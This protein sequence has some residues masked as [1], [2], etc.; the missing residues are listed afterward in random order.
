M[1]LQQYSP[2]IVHPPTRSP[3]NLGGEVIHLPPLRSIVTNNSQGQQRTASHLLPPKH[4]YHQQDGIVE[5]D[6]AVAMMQLA[7]RRQAEAKVNY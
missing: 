3:N 1:S 2:H 5:V 7:S 6:A 4:H